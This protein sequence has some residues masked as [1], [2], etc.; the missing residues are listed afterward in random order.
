VSLKPTGWSR[1]VV[2]SWGRGVVKFE[3]VSESRVIRAS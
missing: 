2:E 3:V 1:G